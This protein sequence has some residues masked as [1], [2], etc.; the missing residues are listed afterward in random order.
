MPPALAADAGSF[1]SDDEIS[2]M[3]TYRSQVRVVALTNV[4]SIL[5]RATASAVMTT[6]NVQK[7]SPT[8]KLQ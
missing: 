1:D 5:C 3:P 8:R 4:I 6:L 2:D 7:C